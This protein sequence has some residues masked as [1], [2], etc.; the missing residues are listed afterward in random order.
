MIL[1]PGQ[2]IA[3]QWRFHLRVIGQI[4]HW[5]IPPLSP[6]ARHNTE[7]SIP[8]AMLTFLPAL[9]APVL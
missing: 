2:R 6:L 3:E 9:L 1:E 5:D 4:R 7:T 8:L